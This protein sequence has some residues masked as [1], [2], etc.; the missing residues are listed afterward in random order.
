MPSPIPFQIKADHTDSKTDEL[1]L[2]LPHSRT[3]T[4]T[5][6]EHALLI[7][8]SSWGTGSLTTQLKKRT[9][10]A[11]TT[12]IDLNRHKT[13]CQEATMTTCHNHS[14]LLLSSGQGPVTTWVLPDAWICSS[15]LQAYSSVEQLVKLITLLAQP[16][17][18]PNP[19]R[20]RSV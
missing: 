15:S 8:Q 17:I 18:L 14:R 13:Q 12:W 9:I 2:F 7:T 3:E 4:E 11:C 19:V 10:C 20:C 6:T 1:N 5:E 16:R